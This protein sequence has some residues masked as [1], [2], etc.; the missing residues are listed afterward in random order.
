MSRYSTLPTVAVL[1]LLKMAW[2]RN[3]VAICA[4]MNRMKKM[5]ITPGWL[6]VHMER[7]LVPKPRPA[8]YR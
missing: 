7:L 8:P 6:R 5:I 4:L 2:N 1:A 3:A